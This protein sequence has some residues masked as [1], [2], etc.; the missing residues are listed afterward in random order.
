MMPPRKRNPPVR[1]TDRAAADHTATTEEHY[2][3]IF[4]I[5]LDNAAENLRARFDKPALGIRSY[6]ALK[7]MLL[8]SSARTPYKQT[9]T[10]QIAI[11]SLTSMS[12]TCNWR[13]FRA[14]SPITLYT[15]PQS[16]YRLCVMKSVLYFV[17]RTS[18][19]A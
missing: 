2:R 10:Y 6:L 8:L 4:F 14:N 19:S 7:K 15:R 13:R 16:T 11:R 9:T 1:Y 18:T 17:H 3:I 12:S 5:I